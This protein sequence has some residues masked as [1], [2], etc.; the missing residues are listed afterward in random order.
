MGGCSC[1]WGGVWVWVGVAVSE[2]WVWVG[3]AVSE[4]WVWV[5]AAVSGVV[6]GCGWVQWLTTISVAMF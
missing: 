4:V 3:A 1:E 6:S 2:V 5:G